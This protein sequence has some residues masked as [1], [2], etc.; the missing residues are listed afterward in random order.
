MVPTVVSFLPF[1]RVRGG[2][3]IWPHENFPTKEMRKPVSTGCGSS[4]LERQ[5]NQ[6]G[7]T[8][9]QTTTSMRNFIPTRWCRIF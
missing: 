5:P 9:L 8:G 4:L 7:L 3:S 2:S 6:M 1:W